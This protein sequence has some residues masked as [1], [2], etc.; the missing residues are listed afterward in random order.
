MEK[1]AVEQSA[2]LGNYFDETNCFE[3]TS[4]NN[5][6]EFL[7]KLRDSHEALGHTELRITNDHDCEMGSKDVYLHYKRLET[8]IECKKREK[9]ELEYRKQMEIES[10][11]Q[12]ISLEKYEK[13]M[14]K[15]LKKKYEG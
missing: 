5:F 6:I 1:R 12:K 4:L 15:K 3:D 2:V 10:A 13:A 8:D 7:I 9:R 14:Y 11:K